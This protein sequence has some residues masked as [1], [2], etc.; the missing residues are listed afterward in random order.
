MGSFAEM[1]N[2]SKFGEEHHKKDQV[3][4]SKVEQTM[5]TIF[6]AIFP[7]HMGRT[8]KKCPMFSSC[9]PFPSRQSI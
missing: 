2:D 7:R 5:I 8:E 4:F 6:L 9:N 3:I 1:H